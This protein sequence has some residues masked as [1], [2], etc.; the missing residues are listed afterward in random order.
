M[1]ITIVGSS[2]FA[3]EMVDYKNQLNDLGHEVNLHEHYQAQAKGD[4][5][6]IRERMSVEHAK[7]KIEN[8]YHKYHYDE[9]VNRSDAILVLNL[10]K[11][12]IKNYI[13]GNT[14]MEMGMAYVHD[15]KIFLLNSIPDMSYSEEIKSLEPVVINGDLKLVV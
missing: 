14:L 8:N 5:K 12:D 9:I 7:V 1:R 15:K 2:K 11:N 10:D 3:K 4:M 13:G 6:E